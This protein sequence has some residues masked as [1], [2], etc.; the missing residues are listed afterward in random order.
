MKKMFLLL[1]LA[2]FSKTINSQILIA[3]LFGDKLNSGKL[4]FGLMVSPSFTNITNIESE[5]RPALNLA[6]FFN[7]RPDRKFFLHMELIAKSSFGGK[8]I[9][10]YSLGNDS[11]DNF[12]LSGSVERIIKTAGVTLLGRYTISPHFFID[13]GVQPDLLFKKGKDIFQSDFNGNELQYTQKL[14]DRFTR[15]DFQVA[16]GLFYKFKA[17]KNSMGI[18]VRYVYGL[19]DIDKIAIGNQVNTTWQINIAIP[20]GATPKEKKPQ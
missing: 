15:L 6:L 10:P 3:V 11:L 7:V 17:N 16:G 12:F 19:T 2:G 18:G 14:E 20:V 8:N 1:L 9:A 4:Q 5:Y 13:A